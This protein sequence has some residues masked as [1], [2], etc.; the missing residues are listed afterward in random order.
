MANKPITTLETKAWEFAKEA[1]K[2]QLRKF[3]GLPY[4]DT[5]VQKV[6]GTLKLYTKEEKLLIAALLHDVIE[7][8]F[9]NKWI[10][11]SIIKELF[12]QEIADIVMELTSCKDE[13][14]YK[15][16]GDKTK[17]LIF[18]M[19]NMSDDA[20]TIKLSDRLN[21]IADSFTA[22]EKFRNKYYKETVD[23]M[24]ALSRREMNK[25]Q[26]ILYN[27]IMSKLKNIET[28]FEIKAG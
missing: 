9:E 5:H 20:F 28:F 10:G 27:D 7:D 16:D 26:T 13:I 11:Y 23:I 2:N 18:K 14:R 8:C 17:Y 15:Y 6:N 19:L 4:F 25:L 1:H 21:N 3:S 24:N 12:G 22:S